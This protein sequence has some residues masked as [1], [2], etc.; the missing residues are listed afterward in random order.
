M[1]SIVKSE[2]TLPMAAVQDQRYSPSPAVKSE[3]SAQPRPP[4]AAF[5]CEYCGKEFNLKQ[6]LIGHVVDIHGETCMPVKPEPYPIQSVSSKSGKH[7]LHG[8]KYSSS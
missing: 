6:Y 7:S 1:K 2:A 5:S 8:E 4:T 3:F